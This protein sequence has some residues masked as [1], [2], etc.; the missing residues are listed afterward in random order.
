[1]AR[2]LI[3]LYESQHAGDRLLS[4]EGAASLIEIGAPGLPREALQEQS[5]GGF[6]AGFRITLEGEGDGRAARWVRH[7]PEPVVGG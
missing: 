7:E 2:F 5:A 6:D 3:A 4:S 1:M